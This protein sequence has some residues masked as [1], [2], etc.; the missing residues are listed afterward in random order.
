MAS[1]QRALAHLRTAVA[2]LH[3]AHARFRARRWL[4]DLVHALVVAWLLLGLLFS[5]QLGHVDFPC[6]IVDEP[7]YAE[8]MLEGSDSS[9]AVVL[10]STYPAQFYGGG[11]ASTGVDYGETVTF[12][13][14]EFTVEAEQVSVSYAETSERL[15]V[16]DWDGPG[17]VNESLLTVDFR[18]ESTSPRVGYP[19]RYTSHERTVFTPIRFH[20]NDSSV[21]VVQ[22]AVDDK[23]EQSV[24]WTA[25]FLLVLA[26]GVVRIGI[27]AA[28]SVRRHVSEEP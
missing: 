9:D 18:H 25:V 23:V 17:R 2:R 3:A 24:L 26:N 1:L 19:A 7:E 4:Y 11:C 20:D 6:G 12:R 28:V 14:M 16:V 8:S 10:V 27:W 5:M 15:P 22:G 21:L 13:G